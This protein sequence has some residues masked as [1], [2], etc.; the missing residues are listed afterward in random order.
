[1]NRSTNLV[2][3]Q[4]QAD[5]IEIPVDRPAM[6]ETTS[7]GSAIAAWFAV[8]IWTNFDELKQINSANRTL[9]RP[10]ITKKESAKLYRV[11]TRAVEMCRGWLDEEE[12]VEKE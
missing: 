9:F 4:T 2:S 10:K 7:L 1:M 5:I 8:G 12:A 3:N 11:W 6:R